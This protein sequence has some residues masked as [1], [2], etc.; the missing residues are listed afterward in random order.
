MA[1]DL[2]AIHRNLESFYKFAD[3]SVIHVGVGGDGAL[4]GYAARARSVLGVDPDPAGIARL[5]ESIQERSLEQ[6]FTVFEGEIAAVEQR[7]ELTLFEFCLHEIE[8]PTA[9]LEHARSLSSEILVIDHLAQSPWSWYTSETEKLERSWAAVRKQSVL[10]ETT[11]DAVQ[12]F[13]DFAELEA[14]LR[15]LGEPTLTR[16]QKLR[17]QSNI[18]I[19]MPYG[20]AL[21]AGHAA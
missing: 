5:E 6:R 17:D 14:K 21:V 15:I 10:R 20:M 12:L 4:T 18:T 16:I 3:R 7:A 1:S 9:A 11:C 19:Q 8:D 2:A 13:A